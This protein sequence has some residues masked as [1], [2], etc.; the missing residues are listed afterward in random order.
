M[1]KMHIKKS[2]NIKAPVEK[3]YSKLNDFNHWTAWSPWLI[4]DPQ[5]T[6][7]IAEDAKSYEWEGE[8]VGSGKRK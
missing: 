8:R 7:T 3:V 6:V 4:M 5:A 2:V 1:P